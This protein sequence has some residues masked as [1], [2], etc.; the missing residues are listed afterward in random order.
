MKFQQNPSQGRQDK[1]A[2]LLRPASKV[3]LIDLSIP[4][5]ISICCVGVKSVM[6]EVSKKSQMEAEI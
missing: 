4:A 5:K 1:A 6:H 3:P 2:K